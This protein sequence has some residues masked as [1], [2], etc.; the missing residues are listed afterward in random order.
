MKLTNRQK[1][2]ILEDFFTNKNGFA[3]K[4]IAQ[5]K[6]IIPAII[7]EEVKQMKK[8][9]GYLKILKEVKDTINN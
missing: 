6:I 1:Q 7:N 2:K 3:D 9:I 4:W 5:A 8:E